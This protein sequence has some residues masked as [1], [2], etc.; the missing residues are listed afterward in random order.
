MVNHGPMPKDKG[1]SPEQTAA[2]VIA[3]LLDQTLQDPTLV[4]KLR[5]V[6][7]NQQTHERAWYKARGIITEKYN[8][9]RELNTML[10]SIGGSVG[11]EDAEI[12]RLE[13]EELSKFDHK[14]RIVMGDMYRSQE[15]EL[16]DL[17]IRTLQ[18]DMERKKFYGLLDEM[19]DV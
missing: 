10:S 17:G 5:T 19:M 15:R 7:A 9:K 8:K 2:L 3:Q 18:D 6:R 1:K 4:E 12:T 14:L 13:R 16:Q 11:L